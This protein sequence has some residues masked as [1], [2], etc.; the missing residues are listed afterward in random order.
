M[1]EATGVVE[2]VTEVIGIR[3][4]IDDVDLTT[5]ETTLTTGEAGR[6]DLVAGATDATRPECGEEGPVTGAA[7]AEPASRVERTNAKNMP[8]KAATTSSAGR[9]SLCSG[10]GG[11]LSGGG[12][13]MVDSPVGTTSD[14]PL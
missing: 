3:L 9:R 8:A 4:T 1:T 12:P 14:L 7:S 5:G 10:T 13:E 11:T 2:L 6:M